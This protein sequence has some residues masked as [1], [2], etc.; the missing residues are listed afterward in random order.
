LRDVACFHDLADAQFTTIHLF[1]YEAFEAWWPNATST[2]M[3][4]DF[5]AVDFERSGFQPH[6]SAFSLFGGSIS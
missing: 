6:G 4:F 5:E 1:V 3:H 2:S